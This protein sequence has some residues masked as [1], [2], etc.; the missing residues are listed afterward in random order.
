MQ[1]DLDVTIVDPNGSTHAQQRNCNFTGARVQVSQLLTGGKSTALSNDIHTCK[2]LCMQPDFRVRY[3]ISV[4]DAAATAS[5]AEYCKVDRAAGWCIRFF[6][7]W[8]LIVPIM[9]LITGPRVQSVLS[10]RQ[11][12]KANVNSILERRKHGAGF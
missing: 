6:V 4:P 2:A 3:E 12:L 7:D 5:W 9:P 10:Y 1:R 8:P 11:L